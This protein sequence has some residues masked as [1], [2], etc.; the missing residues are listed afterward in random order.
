MVKDQLGNEINIGAEVRVNVKHRRPRCGWGE[1]RNG[2]VGTVRKIVHC[3]AFPGSG[4]R[5]TIDFP[6]QGGWS[7]YGDEVIFIRRELCYKYN[8][9]SIGR[10][11]R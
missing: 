9:A 3:S 6:Q 1:I 11:Q 4:N 8:L 2:N 10:G 7:G 5:L